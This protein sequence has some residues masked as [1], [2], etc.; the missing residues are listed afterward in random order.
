MRSDFLVQ[1]GQVKSSIVLG[2]GCSEFYHFVAEELQKCIRDITGIT[3]K[4]IS[5]KDPK[6]LTAQAV[7]A[8]SIGGPEVNAL[9][10]DALAGASVNFGELDLGP[11]GFLLK[12]CRSAESTVIP[13]YSPTA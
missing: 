12:T 7:N 6:Q 9:S 10:R 3:P 11:E 2:D 5:A 8:I 4:I 1:N 13:D